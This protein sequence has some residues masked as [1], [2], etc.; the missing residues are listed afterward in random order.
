MSYKSVKVIYKNWILFFLIFIS[1]SIILAIIRI[2]RYTN[3]LVEEIA[4]LSIITIVIC[5][6]IRKMVKINSTIFFLIVYSAVTSFIIYGLVVPAAIDRSR[7]LFVVQWVNEGNG[8]YSAQELI[9]LAQ[10]QLSIDDSKAI[11]QRFNEQIARKVIT[12]VNENEDLKLTFIGMLTYESANF[13]A[14][15]YN[16]QGWYK[17]SLKIE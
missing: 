5:Y 8:K 14:D 11:V 1:L 6:L 10:N 7:S 16:L 4:I 2:G 15:F 3:F 17:N 9:K 12:N 13:F